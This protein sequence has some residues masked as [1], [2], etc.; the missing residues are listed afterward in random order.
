[1]SLNHGHQA[2]Q[3]ARHDMVFA[4]ISASP[5]PLTIHEI[6]EKLR[7]RM[8]ASLVESAVQRLQANGRIEAATRGR[9]GAI[10]NTWRAVSEELETV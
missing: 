8:P 3:R 6:V 5:R 9:G 10:Q 2:E 4:A 1:M 7:S